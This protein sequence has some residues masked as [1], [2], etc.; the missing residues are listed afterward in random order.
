MKL[1]NQLPFNENGLA[2]LDIKLKLIQFEDY[3]FETTW[4]HSRSRLFH[5]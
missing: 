1:Y 3:L 4:I 2:Q 5:T